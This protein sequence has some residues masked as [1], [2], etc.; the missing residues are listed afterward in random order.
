M[1]MPGR[2]HSPQGADERELFNSLLGVSVIPGRKN[3]YNDVLL[4]VYKNGA[5]TSF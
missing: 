1:K 4:R 3:D 2:I 5:L